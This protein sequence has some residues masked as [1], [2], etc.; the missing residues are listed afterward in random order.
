LQLTPRL[1]ANTSALTV[2]GIAFVGARLSLNISVGHATLTLLSKNSDAD[3]V[4]VSFISTTVGSAP[5]RIHGGD[6]QTTDLI[7]KNSGVSGSRMHGGKDESG[8]RKGVA[9]D[10]VEDVPP[11]TIDV[12]APSVVKLTVG[13]GIRVALG[14]VLNVSVAAAIIQ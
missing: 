14:L 6:E 7:H 2:E 9:L 13:E 5:G 8:D 12:V 10:G 3:D 11:R 1:P 4:Q